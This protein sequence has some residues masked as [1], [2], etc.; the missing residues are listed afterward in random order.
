LLNA[1]VNESSQSTK[2]VW[3][4]IHPIYRFLLLNQT[5]INQNWNVRQ[6]LDS[7]ETR[8]EWNSLPES[9][10]NALLEQQ[11]NDGFFD[12]TF[13][14]LGWVDAETQP[15]SN[16]TLRSIV[17]SSMN[18]LFENITT[19]L[20]KAEFDMIVDMSGLK[21]KHVEIEL[22]NVLE[23]FEKNIATESKSST[24]GKH[25]KTRIDKTSLGSVIKG[26]KNA[27]KYLRAFRFP[28]T[29]NRLF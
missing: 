20:K 15:F 11:A 22:E 28:R 10:K 13:L 1:R 14:D 23:M 25:H 24:L 4:L 26:F 7:N 27:E 16:T 6:K 19:I 17:P 8:L 18:S 9:V 2:Y 29:S 12:Q 5:Q 21:P 3:D